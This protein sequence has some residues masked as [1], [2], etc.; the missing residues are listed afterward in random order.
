MFPD[1]LRDDK[2]AVFKL[3]SVPDTLYEISLKSKLRPKS[4]AKSEWENTDVLQ[5]MRDL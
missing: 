1:F 5:S 2:L 3:L 4:K